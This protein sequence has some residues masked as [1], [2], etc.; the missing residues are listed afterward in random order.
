MEHFFILN[1][2]NL[3][4]LKRCP[5]N[6]YHPHPR[7]NSGMTDTLF[8]FLLSLISHSRPFHVSSQ[9]Q[10]KSPEE[11]SETPF[12]HHANFPEKRPCTQRWIRMRGIFSHD[13][14][15]HFPFPCI[16][17]K[18]DHRLSLLQRIFSL[19]RGKKWMESS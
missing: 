4:A 10:H 3:S 6:A 14:I 15:L 18:Q 7:P 2:F 9:Y 17:R 5:R 11:E 19:R 16:G 8:Q 13:S 1:G 12:L